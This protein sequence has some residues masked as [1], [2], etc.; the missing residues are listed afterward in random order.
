MT[1]FG[2]PAVNAKVWS[3]Y[4]VLL[5]GLT[6]T[7][8]SGSAD[9]T[10]NAPPTT[11]NEWDPI[12]AM[13]KDTPFDDGSET[14]TNED[15]TAAGFGVYAVT[16]SDQKE[17]VTFTAKET[18]LVTLGLVY[19]ASDLT[20]TSGVIS[21]TLKQREPGKKYLL[22]LYRENA[23]EFERKISM[24]YA[25][26]DTISRSFGNNESLCT[27]TMFVSPT[28]SGELYDYYLGPKP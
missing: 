20:K 16:Y 28:A 14:I 26:I 3:K 19:D 1:K 4:A 13:P 25:Q 17:M 21:G 5:G 7:I 2:D 24:N 12:G 11:T 10:L 15:H 9:F 18:T 27:V 6:A 23:T 8:P 22:G